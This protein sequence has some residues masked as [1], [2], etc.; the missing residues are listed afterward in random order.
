MCI[1]CTPLVNFAT[2]SQMPKL[3]HVDIFPLYID[4]TK[5]SRCD[6]INNLPENVFN[7]Y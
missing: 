3:L 7:I 1:N 6:P 5:E 4:D 2:F